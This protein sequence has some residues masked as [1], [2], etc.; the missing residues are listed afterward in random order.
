VEASSTGNFDIPPGARVNSASP[1][2]K[3]ESQNEHLTIGVTADSIIDKA[4]IAIDQRASN[5]FDKLDAHKLFA[6]NKKIPQVFSVTGE[7]EQL[8]INRINEL[9]ASIPMYLFTGGANE[10]TMSFPNLA[11][12]RSNLEITIELQGKTYQRESLSA[13]NIIIPVAEKGVTLPFTV[14]LSENLSGVIPAEE[15]K[16]LLF[17]NG[18]GIKY[19]YL[20]AQPGTIT[21][22][23]SSGQKVKDMNVK[24][25]YGYIDLVLPGGIY[26]VNYESPVTTITNRIIVNR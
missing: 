12:L 10:V 16:P 18:T 21:V 4:V 22:Y 17:Y 11:K 23:T 19:K 24:N 3:S 1:F 9:P 14:H 6:T 13:G 26:L 5:R 2:L 8:T 20:P 15:K 25:S 7:N